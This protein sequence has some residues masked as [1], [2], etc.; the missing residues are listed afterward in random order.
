[1][2]NAGIG[3]G[4]NMKVTPPDVVLPFY[5]YA[6]ISFLAGTLFLYFSGDHFQ[7]QHFQPGILALT[8]IMA[9]GWGTMMILG[10][11]HQLFPVITGQHLASF[12]LAKLSFVLA[13][14]GIPLL[15]YGFYRMNFGWPAQIGGSLVL[16]AVI[17]FLVNLL[18]TRLRS[19][20][21]ELQNW[22]IIAAAIWLLITVLAGL[23]LV[24]NFTYDF[25]P[26][27]SLAYLPL[28]AH[29]GIAG[30]FFLL[31]IGVGSRLI[32]M[33]LL[34]KYTNKGLLWMMFLLL[35][36]GLL[37]FIFFFFGNNSGNFLLPA[38]LISMAFLLFLYYTFRSY[39]VRLRRK[40]DEP[41][42]IALA[43]VVMMGFP[44]V[45]L[46]CLVY[47]LN[48][49]ALTGK[50]ALL[51]GFFI[52]F[53]WLTMIILGMTFKTLPFIIWNKTYHS[54]MGLKPLPGPQQLFSKGL[55]RM[56][57]IFYVPGFVLF[58][59][60]V[61]VSSPLLIRV[62]SGMLILAAIFYNWNVLKLIFHK[63]PVK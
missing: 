27:N 51:Y 37:S 4:N 36:A 57:F 52:F 59:I 10:A 11:S 25:L 48:T 60:A 2:L 56:M 28:H 62:A 46:F 8:H 47:L 61:A 26:L 38:A 35:N 29:A 24:F 23:L 13:A 49:T 12:S 32:P 19:R 17:C 53:G 63:A 22:F 43:A 9:L 44:L 3:S 21:A 30:W 50:L 6:A 41:M 45:V 31:V 54:E 58:I 18:L 5:A 55:F 39:Q 15:V 14:P 7:G 42:K 1:M 34:S 16:C 33:F 20:G 40:I